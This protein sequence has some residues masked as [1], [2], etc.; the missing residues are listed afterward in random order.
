M[1][2]GK[3]NK[4]KGS[5]IMDIEDAKDF[6]ETADGQLTIYYSFHPIGT[7]DLKKKKVIK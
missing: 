4:W 7:I 6:K 1:Y 5:F 2:Y 3:K